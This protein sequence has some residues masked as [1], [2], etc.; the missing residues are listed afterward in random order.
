MLRLS[1]LS[2]VKKIKGVLGVNAQRNCSAQASEKS[3]V[4]EIK[5][6]TEADVVIIGNFCL[7][8]VCACFTFKQ[9]QISKSRMKFRLT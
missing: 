4:N 8:C 3:T 1:Q 5:F 6:P 2:K 7:F 9:V